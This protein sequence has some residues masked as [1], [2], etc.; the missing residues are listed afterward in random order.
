MPFALFNS[1]PLLCFYPAVR[2]L[3][4]FMPVQIIPFL[5]MFAKKLKKKKKKIFS[6]KFYTVFWGSFLNVMYYKVI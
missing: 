1:I 3:P 4:F 6:V 2:L 5:L